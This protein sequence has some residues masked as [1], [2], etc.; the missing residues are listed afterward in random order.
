MKKKKIFFIFPLLFLMFGFYQMKAQTGVKVNYYDDTVQEFSVAEAGR[1]YFN[2]TN[3]LISTDGTNTTTIP[4]SIIRSVEF[5]D[6][7]ELA[8]TEVSVKDRILVYPNPATN[9]IRI[10]TD[11][12][13]VID[14]KIYNAQGQLAM[15]GKYRSNED[16]DVSQ[17]GTGVYIVKANQSTIKLLKK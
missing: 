5:V 11:T 10:A 8:T 2:S 3:F 4:I 13:E 7:S 15:S 6:A 16:I 9:Y 12:N 17:L 14:V 1:L